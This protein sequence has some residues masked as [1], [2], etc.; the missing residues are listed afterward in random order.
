MAKTECS[1]LAK[2]LT[3]I[4]MNI[5]SREGVKTL[6]DVVMRMQEHF[7]E[8]R[9]AD[10]VDAIVEA[11]SGEAKQTNELAKKLAEIKQEAKTDK[12]LRTAIDELE[13]YLESGTLPQSG[14]RESHTTDVIEKLRD[15]RDSLRKQL[16]Q[17]DPAKVARVEKQ[18]ETLEAKIKSGDILPKQKAAD[19]PQ[20]KEL[21]KLIYERDRIRNEIRQAIYDLKPK[22]VWERIAEPFNTIRAIMTTGEFSLVLRQ[23]G[24]YFT[25]HP[26][27]GAKALGTMFKAFVSDMATARINS[28]ILNRDNAPLYAKSKLYLSPIDGMSRLVQMEEAFMARTIEKIPLIKNFQRSGLTFLNKIR[29][30]QFDTMAATLGKNST[31]TLEEAKAIS[32]FINESTG[33]GSLGGM[34]KAAVQLNTVFFAPKYLA[35]R[36]QMIAGHSMWGGTARTR[37]LIAK[38]YARYVIG[39]GAVYAL[40]QLAGGEL[41]EDPRSSDFGKIKFGNA[42]LDPLSGMAQITTFSARILTGETKTAK[43]IK[44]IRGDNVPYGGTTTPDV[45]ARFLRSK[46]SPTFSIP[47]DI[48]AGE[49]L[50]G[51]PVTVGSMA[52]KSLMPLT[53]GEI[54]DAMKSE[55]LPEGTAL[56]LLTFFGMGLQTY[57]PQKPKQSKVRN[58][59]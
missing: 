57:Q 33:R 24:I 39:M 3:E 12:Q 26:I 23:G 34:E 25:S 15:V 42:R 56:G 48:A 16:N 4:A 50:G 35:S 49:D 38:E 21:E 6:D 1:E 53:Y 28:E 46:L 20:S 59:F 36:F 17:T 54:Y 52:Q 13:K 14:T 2:T 41:E 9:R 55:G 29:A 18:I 51:N 37:T 45:I 43:G 10:V 22:T 5:G 8:I 7:P 40:G 30:D 32:T 44:P 11:T 58:V 27:K 19:T 47:I 31:V